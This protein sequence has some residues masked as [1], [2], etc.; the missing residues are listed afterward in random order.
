MQR[1]VRS[2]F[3]FH[4]A[5]LN[6]NLGP[7]MWGRA[8][9]MGDTAGSCPCGSSGDGNRFADLVHADRSVL[10]KRHGGRFGDPADLDCVCHGAG[11][12]DLAC[13]YVGERGEFLTE[14][15]G[16][17]VHEEVVRFAVGEGDAGLGGPDR[18]LGLEAGGDAVL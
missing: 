7:S 8:C 3:P 9:P 12:G 16:E 13:H 11:T 18:P 17:P 4:G 6:G 15:V 2:F 5:L 1:L 14:R 10:V